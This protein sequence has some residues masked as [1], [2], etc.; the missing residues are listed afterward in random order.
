[1]FVAPTTKSVRDLTSRLLANKKAH[2][3]NPKGRRANNGDQQPKLLMSM[4]V[5]QAVSEQPFA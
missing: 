1:M 5:T 4:H 2:D 3:E